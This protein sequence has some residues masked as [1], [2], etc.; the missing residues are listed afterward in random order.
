[1]SSHE[2]VE[3]WSSRAALFSKQYEQAPTIRTFLVHLIYHPKL[4]S[5]KAASQSSAISI[6][7][8]E[9][10]SV[11]EPLF[12]K[13]R[14][15]RI[16]SRRRAKS[17]AAREKELD[18]EVVVLEPRTNPRLLVQKISPQTRFKISLVDRG[19]PDQRV[20]TPRGRSRANIPQKSTKT[21]AMSNENSDADLEPI[22]PRKRTRDYAFQHRTQA[23]IWADEDE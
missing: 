4:R 5:Q 19:S 10:E 20:V 22:T 16:S 21:T 15:E 17:V 3:D 23:N 7:G 1:V 13:L 18:Y 14:A 2:E 12:P 8:I 11:D 9:I 6:T